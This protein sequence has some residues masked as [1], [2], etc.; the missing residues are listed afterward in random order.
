MSIY[1][2]SGNNTGYYTEIISSFFDHHLQPHAE[3]VKTYIK[4]TNIFFKE[5]RF[6]R[7]LLHDIIL[8]TMDVLYGYYVIF[9][10]I[11]KQAA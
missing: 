10:F 11:S 6:L 2:Y 4:D 1:H 3:A 8:C 9:R 5:L 7:K